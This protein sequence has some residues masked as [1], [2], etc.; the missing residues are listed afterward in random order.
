MH[1]FLVILILCLIGVYTAVVDVRLA[2]ARG[3]LW[4]RNLTNEN[5]TL[6]P[7]WGPCR[8]IMSRWYYD[9]NSGNCKEFLYG[10]CGGNGNNFE[11]TDECKQNCSGSGLRKKNR[12]PK[13]CTLEAETGPCRA[14]IPRWYFNSQNGT[15][16]RFFY[17]G[18]GGNEN[19]F[20]TQVG[21]NRRC[22]GKKKNRGTRKS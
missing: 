2:E 9:Y 14:M 12:K 21:C 3:G 6:E 7:D 5:C 15:C 10:G 22:S 17:G 16:V 8:A 19:N 18:C 1:R 13:N 20:K 4:D 11:T